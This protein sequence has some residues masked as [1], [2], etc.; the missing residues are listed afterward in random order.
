MSKF[1]SEEVA[2]LQTEIGV[3]SD[4]G[5]SRIQQDK[6]GF[7]KSQDDSDIF[8]M[9]DGHGEDGEVIAKTVVDTITSTVV[10]ID[11]STKTVEEMRIFL[12]LL[13]KQADEA[14]K[15]AIIELHRNRNNEIFE[16]VDGVLLSQRM[17]KWFLVKGGATCTIVIRVKYLLFCGTVGD[18]SVKVYT[19]VPILHDLFKRSALDTTIPEEILEYNL[20]LPEGC[21]TNHCELS[22]TPSLSDPA[23]FRRVLKYPTPGIFC[24]DS[25][26]SNKTSC[27]KI[28]T[29]GPDN[30]LVKNKE[31]GYPKNVN[32]ELV[33]MI[34]APSDYNYGIPPEIRVTEKICALAMSRSLAD[35]PLK[36]VGVSAEPVI[37]I[38]DM[39]PL[40]TNMRD[41]DENPNIKIVLAS[42][43]LWDNMKES[44]TISD[45][46]EFLQ[47][48][49]NIT[50]DAQTIA[51][52]L[53]NENDRCGRRNFGNSRDNT[54]II[55]V[56]FTEEN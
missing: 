39:E 16:T 6:C 24:Y 35:F 4:I 22:H 3:Y 55:V 36:P 56:K 29:I 27:H 38:M 46:C 54:T 13:C 42:D 43:G 49:E 8:I 26:I 17:N 31:R 37:T 7:C 18:S 50:K 10:D 30:E 40:F 14:C 2:S 48:S 34:V 25:E 20:T 53:G 44:D 19:S 33:T 47:K 1:F 15:V 52:A 45:T 12:S 5:G 21:L 23:E 11:L 51:T 9:A 32:R 41:L 28:F